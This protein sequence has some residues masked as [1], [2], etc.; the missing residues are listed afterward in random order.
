MSVLKNVRPISPAVWP[1][2]RNIYTNVFFII[3]KALRSNINIY[4]SAIA[5]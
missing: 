1:A 3:D 2:I 5:D 4:M